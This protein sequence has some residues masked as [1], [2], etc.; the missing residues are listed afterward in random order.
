MPSS[1]DTLASTKSTRHAS[2]HAAA[3][4]A[5]PAFFVVEYSNTDN[6]KDNAGRKRSV[7][8]DDAASGQHKTSRCRRVVPIPLP[9]APPSSAS[10]DATQQ[11][12]AAITPGSDREDSEADPEELARLAALT[13]EQQQV[14]IDE[15]FEAK[16]VHDDAAA[17]LIGGPAERGLGEA[18]PLVAATR[19][20]VECE[21]LRELRVE[22][23][24]RGRRFVLR[25]CAPSFDSSASQ[26]RRPASSL[27]LTRL[28]LSHVPSSRAPRRSRTVGGDGPVRPIAAPPG[29]LSSLASPPLELYAPCD[30]LCCTHSSPAEAAR[31]A[32]R[33]GG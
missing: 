3:A 22:R 31:P 9:A 18:H 27:P 30:G 10:S 8:E 24:D 17:M 33:L 13:E 5:A 20:Q 2:L 19:L 21:L 11:L 23:E 1:T 12:S 32:R 7:P 29:S 16:E 6:E 25:S 28:L 26:A 4:A 15:Y 14:L